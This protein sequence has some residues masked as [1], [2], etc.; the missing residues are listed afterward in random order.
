MTPDIVCTTPQTARATRA[1]FN[2][3]L[4]KPPRPNTFAMEQIQLWTRI[5]RG[6]GIW[7]RENRGG[8][9]G[10]LLEKIRS[11]AARWGGGAS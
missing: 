2:T 1:H 7:S 3:L 9:G 4:G 8:G 5:G 11:N 6:E 10:F